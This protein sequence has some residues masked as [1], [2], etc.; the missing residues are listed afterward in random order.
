M[1]TVSESN[2]KPQMKNPPIYYQSKQL[3][4]AEGAGTASEEQL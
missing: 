4:S 1:R 3:G 2:D